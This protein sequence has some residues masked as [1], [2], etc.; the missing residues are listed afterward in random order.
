MLKEAEG[1]QFVDDPFYRRLRIGI[2]RVEYYQKKMD[3][4]ETVE[5]DMVKAAREEMDPL[6]EKIKERMQ[7]ME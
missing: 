6:Y 5:L 2:S 1:D 7:T 4:I 3:E